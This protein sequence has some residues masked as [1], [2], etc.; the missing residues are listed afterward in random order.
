M[1]DSVVLLCCLL[2]ISGVQAQSDEVEF[3][4]YK[5][6]FKAKKVNFFD[7][8]E[9]V[10]FIRLEETESSLLAGANMYIPFEGGFAIPHKDSRKVYIFDENGTFVN[11]I[12]CHGQGPEEYTGFSSVWAKGEYLEL[13]SSTQA[14]LFRFQLNGEFVEKV[15][16]KV[17]MFFRA[18]YAAPFG[19]G[20]VVTVSIRMATKDKFKLPGYRLLYFDQDLNF[21]DGA[22]AKLPIH[23]FPA[24]LSKELLKE[25]DQLL[26]KHIF[27]D[28]IYVVSETDVTPYMKIDMGDAWPWSD[29]ENSADRQIASAM[30]FDE[31]LVM[32]VL[33][34]VGADRVHLLA[35]FTTKKKTVGYIDRS[36]G[37]YYR[38][39]MRRNRI[40]DFDLKAIQ[41][42]GD[43]LVHSL[44]SDELKAFVEKLKGKPWKVKGGYSIGQIVKSENPVL[45]FIKFKAL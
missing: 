12:H 43:H 30:I 25:N 11:V 21:I 23:A 28:S 5:I 33:P 1:R 22:P 9:E 29:P 8:V 13:F 36:T 16:L 19:A 39:D 41:W 3:Y 38:F 26:Y 14:T 2:T 37:K 45:A 34:L 6:D 10:E 27:T 24:A 15:P 40:G 32:D 7:E 20:Y 44:A 35:Y 18:G 4:H 42:E 17:P 31:S